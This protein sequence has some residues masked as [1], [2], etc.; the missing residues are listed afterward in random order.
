MKIVADYLYILMVDIEILIK[1]VNALVNSPKILSFLS[2]FTKNNFR[3]HKRLIQSQNFVK[4]LWASIL[5][6]TLYD[7]PNLRKDQSL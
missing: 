3:I 1:S 7:V 5:N 2:Y 6:Y 4:E